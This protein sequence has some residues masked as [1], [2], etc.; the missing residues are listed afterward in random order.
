MEMG[1]FH[2]HQWM[3]FYDFIGLSFKTSDKEI[4]YFSTPKKKSSMN[5]VPMVEARDLKLP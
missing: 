3:F 4:P 1:E 2:Q 5:E